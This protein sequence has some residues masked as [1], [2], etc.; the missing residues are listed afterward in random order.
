M[1]E[2]IKLVL[3]LIGMELE[4]GPTDRPVWPEAIVEKCQSSWAYFK[5]F[6]R[7]TGEYVAAHVLAMVR[8]HY[9]GVDLRRLEAGV[10][11]NTDPV[12]IEQLRATS[13]ATATKIISVVDLCSET[14][15][16]N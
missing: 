11:S 4:E 12:K 9:P 16:T 10:S 15:Q 6:I 14:G 7:D 8:S 13:Q 2:G 1:E 3:D 5:Q